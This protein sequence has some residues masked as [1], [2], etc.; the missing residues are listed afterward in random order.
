MIKL[1]IGIPTYKREQS[2]IVLLK[3]INYE[4]ANVPVE[5]LIIN[6]DPEKVVKDSVENFFNNYLVT[7]IN[8]KINCGGQENSLR[9]YENAL[10]EYV[11]YLGD[12]D[13]LVEGSIN[14]VLKLLY[15]HKPEILM[16]DGD[17]KYDPINNLNSGTY[18]IDSILEAGIPL[19]KLIFAPQMI[20]SK[21][22]IASALPEAR[23]YLGT[24]VPVFAMIILSK[25]KEIYYY[26]EEKFTAQ[27]DQGE[28][29]RKDK[30]SILPVF[31]GISGLL[32][33]RITLDRRNK[34]KKLIRKES[35]EFLGIFKVLGSIM[36]EKLRENICNY[37][38]Y[39]K[40]AFAN[41]SILK[42]IM[43]IFILNIIRLLP[44]YYLKIILNK[45][46]NKLL[47]KNI[48]I[49][50]FQDFSRI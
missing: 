31:L 3:Q 18:P 30:Y 39:Y 45:F 34:I 40:S 35:N 24:F 37:T 7:I 17:P 9:V 38:D 8:N 25:V 13:R 23:L 10:G 29:T 32:A 33:M 27:C 19:R 2:L 50:K 6:N 49:E 21:K 47:K 20:I 16:F 28:V 48:D 11:W 36:I 1:T 42:F 15:S 26:K 46:I 5:I 22:S 4:N 12:D 43:F 41:Y 14:K 44:K